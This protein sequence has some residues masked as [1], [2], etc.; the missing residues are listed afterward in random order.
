NIN[1]LVA[2]DVAARGI[3]V[4][5]LTHVINFAIPQDPESYVHR[6]GRTGRAGKEGNAITFITPSEY[7][8]LQYIQKAAKT[9]IRKAKLPGVGEVVNIKRK[10]VV[11]RLEEI[12]KSQPKP[13]YMEMSDKLLTDR[14][15]RDVIAALLQYAFAEELDYNNYSE[16]KDTIV[17]AKGTTRLFVRQ[18]K[19]DGLSRKKLAKIIGNKCNVDTE[20][21]RD[22]QIFD[23]FSFVTLP[24]GEAEKV[25][26]YFKRRG[27]DSGLFITRAKKEKNR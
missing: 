2:T 12:I 17:D 5:D 11:T 3:D 15:P 19:H 25:L 7:R 27:S 9:A 18:G 20:K 23:K 13:T 6:I 8:K 1:I 10:R 14:D 22:V 4:H 16:I 24:F 21:I 26:S